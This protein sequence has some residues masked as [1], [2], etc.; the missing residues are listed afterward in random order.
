VEWFVREW[1][2]DASG[3][4]ELSVYCGACAAFS[5]FDGF[6]VAEYAVVD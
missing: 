6:A 3:A 4:S 1:V 2:F 5:W